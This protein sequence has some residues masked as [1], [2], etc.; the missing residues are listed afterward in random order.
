MLLNLTRHTYPVVLSRVAKFGVLGLALCLALLAY[1]GW[2]ELTKKPVS[3]PNVRV[4]V[5]D[6][7]KN[8]D[9]PGTAMPAWPSGKDIAKYYIRQDWTDSKT[10]KVQGWR[11]LEPG[12]AL[13][14]I[15]YGVRGNRITVEP[16]WNSPA[17]I[18][19]CVAKFGVEVTFHDLPRA[20][21]DIVFQ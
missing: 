5:V 21:Y 20:N 19:M 9:P 7:G 14:D 15:S 8:D 3:D 4:L 10:L 11:F 13:D 2:R 12:H 18:A 1:E 16:K 6:C 17:V